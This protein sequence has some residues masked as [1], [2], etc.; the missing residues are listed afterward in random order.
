MYVFGSIFNYHWLWYVVNTIGRTIHTN[1][2]ILELSK[3]GKILRYGPSLSLIIHHLNSNSLKNNDIFNHSN[4]N[5]YLVL[6]YID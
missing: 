4:K 2:D 6:H 1:L 3:P 5:T